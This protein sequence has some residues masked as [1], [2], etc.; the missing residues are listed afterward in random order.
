VGIRRIIGLLLSIYGFILHHGWWCYG[1]SLAWIFYYISGAHTGVPHT[2]FFR[3]GEPPEFVTKPSNEVHNKN[4]FICPFS[5]MLFADFASRK[6]FHQS[7][8]FQTV[9]S[10]QDAWAAQSVYWLNRTFACSGQ[11][12]SLVPRICR[13]ML[14]TRNNFLLYSIPKFSQQ[15]AGYYLALLHKNFCEAFGKG[16]PRR[17]DWLPASV[18]R[19]LGSRPSDRFGID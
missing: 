6:W 5:W 1:A 8:K 10:S 9:I 7:F 12:I 17:A 16:P 3:S 19:W 13:F 15:C 11:L 14:L 2:T 18:T 4:C